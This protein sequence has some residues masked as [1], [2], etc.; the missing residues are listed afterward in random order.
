MATMFEATVNEFP[1]VGDL[2]RAEKRQAKS[3]WE[4]FQEFG[5]L[6]E[7][8]GTP[9]PPVLAAKLLGISRQRVWELANE[10]KLDRITFEGHP[11]ITENSLVALAK[12]E[13][14]AGRPFKSPVTISETWKAACE[15]AK[16]SRK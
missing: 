9:V 12:S 10:G 2:P 15:V 13:R 11:F 3:L 5:R 16:D 7:E 4:R 14:K 6:A 8:T 1:F